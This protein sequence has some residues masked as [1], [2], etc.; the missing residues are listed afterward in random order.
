MEER[1]KIVTSRFR[2]MTCHHVRDMRVHANGYAVMPSARNII[3][4]IMINHCFVA[5]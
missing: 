5:T 4:N 3:A 2:C 1:I